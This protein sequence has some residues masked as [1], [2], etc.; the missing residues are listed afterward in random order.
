M[1][2]AFTTALNFELGMQDEIYKEMQRKGWYAAEQAGP[3]QTQKV[4]QKYKPNC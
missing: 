3:Q 4:K 2:Q 1:R